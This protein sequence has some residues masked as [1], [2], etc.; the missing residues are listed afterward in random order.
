M[1]PIEILFED[2]DLLVLNKPSDILVHKSMIDRHDKL[3]IVDWLEN[4]LSAKVFSVHRLDKPT[5]GCLIFAKSKGIA[6]KINGLFSEHK[7][8]KSYIAI[9]R[10][11][12]D[13]EGQIDYPLKEEIDKMEDSRTSRVLAAKSAITD[14][15]RLATLE[16]PIPNKRHSTTR[17]S[18]VELF[19][20]TGRKHQLRRHMA[21]IRHP[22]IGDT[23]HGDGTQNTIARTHLGCHRLL[24]HAKTLTLPHPSSDETLKIIACPPP[25]LS[26]ILNLFE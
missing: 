12:T 18:L 3:N 24:L 15:K 14:Y 21:H 22:I 4:Q 20:K 11:Y 7:V 17:Y 13:E 2:T 1:P 9:V 8:V 23:R 26:K 16:L 5:S 25:E 19:P 10:G 6:Q